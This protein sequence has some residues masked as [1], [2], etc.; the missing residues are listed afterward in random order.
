MDFSVVKNG[1]GDFT[2]LVASA[3]TQ[4]HEIYDIDLLNDTAKL[5]VQYGDFAKALQRVVNALREV[6]RR[7]FLEDGIPA[8]SSR[9]RPRSTQPMTTRLQ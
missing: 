9:S 3:N 8:Y 1:P 7:F 5:K 4:P 6:R 2:L